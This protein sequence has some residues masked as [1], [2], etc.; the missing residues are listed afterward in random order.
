MKNLQRYSSKY[1]QLYLMLVG[2]LFFGFFS[3]QDEIDFTEGTDP[4]QNTNTA[5][6]ENTSSYRR[7]GMFDGSSDDV[8][9]NN[10]CSS[11]ILPVSLTANGIPLTLTSP[12]DFSLV[13]DIFNQSTTDEDV[14]AFDFPIQIQNFD[15]SIQ[16]ISS[17]TELQSLIFECDQ[18]I[19]NDENPIICVDFNY[20]I[21]FSLF[22]TNLGL[23]DIFSINSD[24]E[25][26]VF[27]ENL[28]PDD[29]FSA[30]FPLNVLVDGQQ[31]ISVNSDGELEGI[32]DTCNTQQIIN[33]PLD[34]L[35]DLLTQVSWQIDS[36]LENGND[37]TSAFSEYVFVFDAN[38]T[39][40][41]TH[42]S[43]PLTADGTWNASFMNSITQLDINFP[44][45]PLFS[46]LSRNWTIVSISTNEFVLQL[47]DTTSV[48]F[49]AL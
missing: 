15:Y 46:P 35:E 38:N 31:T 17:A 33:D 47:N 27:I 32:I 3:C 12:T 5:T 11:V 7:I 37:L 41:A 42:N 34:T 13:E 18:L 16:Q 20:P 14:I 2:C 8:I 1:R 44:G 40:T 26:F 29:L 36:V 23:F 28:L 19:L 21:S 48:V 39:L 10:S 49:T 30:Q 9:D 45:D 22:N 24:Q 43:L 25:L 4:N 6:S